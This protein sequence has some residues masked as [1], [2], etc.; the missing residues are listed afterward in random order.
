MEDAN[1]FI[2]VVLGRRFFIAYILAIYN[3]MR[4]GEILGLKWK[5]CELENARLS[6]S[7]TLS[8]VKEGLV[9]QEPKT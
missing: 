9:F 2:K 6:V 3:G 1:Q 4:K 5:N 8:K 7:Q